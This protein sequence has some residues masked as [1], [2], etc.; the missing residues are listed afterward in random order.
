MKAEMFKVW[1]KRDKNELAMS[2]IQFNE[3]FQKG[4]AFYWD[5]EYKQAD[6]CLRQCIKMAPDSAEAHLT[7]GWTLYRQGYSMQTW[8]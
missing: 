1:R 8:M 7:L 6:Y 5:E 3:V 2:K 4:K